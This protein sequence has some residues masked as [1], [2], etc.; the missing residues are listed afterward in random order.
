MI[1]SS[2]NETGG[3]ISRLESV[4]QSFKELIQD[5]YKSIRESRAKHI[6]TSMD[7]F[8]YG[9]G[10]RTNPVCDLLSLIRA[11]RQVITRQVVEELTQEDRRKNQR[12]YKGFEGTGDP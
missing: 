9:F 6:Q 7:V 2:H 11:S 1:E 4:R 12:K 8:V 10:L 3:H 5:A